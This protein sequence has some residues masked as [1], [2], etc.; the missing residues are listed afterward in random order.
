MGGPE[1]FQTGMGHTF[2]QGTMPRIMRALERIA[3]AL[4]RMNPPPP[5]P[6]R[7]FGSSDAPTVG[8]PGGGE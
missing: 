6:G 8:P 3:D 5:P 2:Y 1:F 7:S 4:E